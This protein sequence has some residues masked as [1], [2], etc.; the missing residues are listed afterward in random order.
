MIEGVFKVQFAKTVDLSIVE[1][2]FVYDVAGFEKV[3]ALAVE[4]AL[5]I[6]W[7]LVNVLVAGEKVGD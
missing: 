1:L 7:A 5:W 6:V 3:C 2:S 4:M